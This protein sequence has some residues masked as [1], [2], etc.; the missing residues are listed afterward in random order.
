MICRWIDGWKVSFMEIDRWALIRYSLVFT[1]TPV[2]ACLILADAPRLIADVSTRMRNLY[3][4]CMAISQSF[5][6]NLLMCFHVFPWVQILFLLLFQLVLLVA[7][8]SMLHFSW[9]C[10]CSLCSCST[11][12]L[13]VPSCWG[14]YGRTMLSRLCWRKI[15][16]V[17]IS[18]R[19]WATLSGF[20]RSIH[21]QDHDK[22]C[23]LYNPPWTYHSHCKMV[24]GTWNCLFGIA[25]FQVL[26]FRFRVVSKHRGTGM[27]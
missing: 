22:R 8:L 26:S 13:L 11:L 2:A 20:S 23:H 14:R 7:M 18:C 21:V 25:Y 17:P 24:V 9:C 10:G 5:L 4:V 3:T 6:T 19:G 12:N 15:S 1:V 27:D 16:S